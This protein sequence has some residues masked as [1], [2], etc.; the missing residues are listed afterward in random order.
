MN[1]KIHD[2]DDV[3]HVMLCEHVCVYVYGSDN[4]FY[5]SNVYEKVYIYGECAF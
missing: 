4:V 2:A 5:F 3:L 1:V